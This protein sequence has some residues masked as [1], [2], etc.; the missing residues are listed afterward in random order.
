MMKLM[1]NFHSEEK[2]RQR[3]AELRWPN[4]VKC[5]RC[6]GDKYAYDSKRYVYDCYSCG[7][8]FTLISN[9]MLHDTHL[10][11][12]KWFI[13]V[14]MM[15][16][17]KKGISANQLKRTLDVSYKT[18]WYLCHRI[19]T[20]MSQLSDG[21][22]RVLMSGIIE[23]D[24]T[25][26]GPDA[27]NGV[28]MN[29]S[30]DKFILR[31]VDGLMSGVMVSNASVGRPFVGKDGYRFWSDVLQGDFM[32]SLTGAVRRNLKDYFTVPLYH[33]YHQGLVAFVASPLPFSLTANK[34]LVH[35]DD[36]RE[37][38]S[39]FP[40][41]ILAYGGSDTMAEIPSGFVRHIQL[42]LQLVSGDSLFGLNNG[43]DSQEPLPEGK[44]SILKHG[45]GSDRELVAA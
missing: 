10:P 4:G 34:G 22:E 18:A 38:H 44:V 39:F 42:P 8:Q 36:A 12:N 9:T 3:L 5:P 7:Y 11:L 40:V 29:V 27:F 33:T 13:A 24:E 16:E 28:G 1:E 31:M 2:C 25:F 45:S 26:V 37:Q 23:M 30:P 41:C 35:S 6:D 19:R 21:E 15:C 14:Y 43:V 20:A 17:S 32:E